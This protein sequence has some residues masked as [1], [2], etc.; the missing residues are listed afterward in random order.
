MSIVVVGAS[1]EVAG[2]SDVVVT[3]VDAGAAAVV[4]VEATLSEPELLHAA[5]SRHDAT[6]MVMA[7]WRIAES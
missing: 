2:S 6:T 1:V 4:V 3:A 7:V 5:R